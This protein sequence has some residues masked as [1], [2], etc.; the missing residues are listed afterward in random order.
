MEQLLQLG[1]EEFTAQ[2]YAEFEEETE[3]LLEES[4]KD[5]ESE[6]YKSILSTLHQIK[7]T[8]STLGLHSIA[9]M[10]KKLEHDIKKDEFTS[11][12]QDFTMLTNHFQLYKKV[13]KDKLIKS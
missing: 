8:S 13:Y 3:P 6:Q 9:E 1:G 2:L 10:A 5:V 4:K 11:V 7:G 12:N